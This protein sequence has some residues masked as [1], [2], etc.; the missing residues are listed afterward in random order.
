MLL[1]KISHKD[2]SKDQPENLAYDLNKQTLIWLSTD[3]LRATPSI[4]FQKLISLNTGTLEDIFIDELYHLKLLDY[5][6]DYL[7]K[8]IKKAY[9]DASTKLRSLK[10]FRHSGEDAF[11]HTLAV[12]FSTLQVSYLIYGNNLKENK[13]LIANNIIT[14]LL[15]D[16]IEDAA[17]TFKNNQ[18]IFSPLATYSEQ[19]GNNIGMNL[20]FLTKFPQTSETNYLDGMKVRE[21]DPT[22]VIVK[23]MDKCCN[24]TDMK[25]SPTKFI[26]KNL[27]ESADYQ[28]L[29][30][31]WH[32]QSLKGN[33]KQALPTEIFW[34]FEKVYSDIRNEYKKLDSFYERV[35]RLA[36]GEITRLEAFFNSIE[37]S[38]NLAN[39]NNLIT[40]FKEKNIQENSFWSKTTDYNTSPFTANKTELDNAKRAARKNLLKLYKKIYLE[41]LK[42]Y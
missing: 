2:I 18:N 35:D 42:N 16:V 28:N 17:H 14:A 11:H 30:L 5:R 39:N 31:W 33:M 40:L 3:A 36:T 24:L 4:F 12:A 41:I 19:F 13:N 34:I 29:I 8:K 1:K 23:T 10:K 32:A 20:A 6:E 22:V 7:A 25:K 37:D 21:I 38:I 26:K 27:K 9:L 15:H